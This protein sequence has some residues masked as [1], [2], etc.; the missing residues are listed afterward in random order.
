MKLDK[1]PVGITQGSDEIL[2]WAVTG[3][4]QADVIILAVAP[5]A[6]GFVVVLEPVDSYDAW[7]ECKVASRVGRASRPLRLRPHGQ[8]MAVVG[9]SGAILWRA[10][11]P[12][13]NEDGFVSRQPAQAVEIV[14]RDP[15]VRAVNIVVRCDH[16]DVGR[17]GS[18][19]VGIVIDGQ[20]V[21]EV[22]GLPVRLVERVLDESV[23]MLCQEVRPTANDVDAVSAGT[24]A[25]WPIA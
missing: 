18:N 17:H 8:Q 10:K 14:V 7:N 13:R 16:V 2:V 24:L 21:A 22:K 3:V 11:K 6:L 20:A 4:H 5:A 23:V 25:P 1:I 12:F 9:I 19:G 15:A